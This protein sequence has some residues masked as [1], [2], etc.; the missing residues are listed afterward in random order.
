MHITTYISHNQLDKW[1]TFAWN[2][3]GPFIRN[4]QYLYISPLEL[5]S[6]YTLVSK[7]ELL[8]LQGLQGGLY[9]FK[10]KKPLRYE[11]QHLLYTRRSVEHGTRAL[12][13]LG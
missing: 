1:T 2:K 8:L 5:F 4:S 10:K 3:H 9:H 12:T 6:G 7:G 11:T 13:V